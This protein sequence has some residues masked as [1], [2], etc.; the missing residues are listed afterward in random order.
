[1]GKSSTSPGSC[2]AL[3]PTDTWPYES[4]LT[5]ATGCASLND[6]PLGCRAKPECTWELTT[7]RTP[8]DYDAQITSLGQQYSV[9]LEQRALDCS[10]FRAMGADKDTCDTAKMHIADID[11]TFTNMAN[12]LSSDITGVEKKISSVDVQ[13]NKL[14][15]ENAKLTKKL[16]SALNLDAGAQGQIT[17]VQ[18]L[19]NQDLVAN[20]ILGLSMV[21]FVVILLLTRDVSAEAVKTQTRVLAQQASRTFP[22]VTSMIP[23]M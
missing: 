22:G 6:D 8:D 18:L 10:R 3:N 12:D 9:Y 7:G 17:D 15:L 11:S 1:M 21:G 23:G 5:N 13:I 4:G 2:T 20:W 16:S 14:E 19:Y